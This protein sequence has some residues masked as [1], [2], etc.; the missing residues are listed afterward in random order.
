MCNP[1]IAIAITPETL[2]IITNAHYELPQAIMNPDFKYVF[3]VHCS[4][5]GHETDSIMEASNFERLYE[6]D[7]SK[8]NSW[9]FVTD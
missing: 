7:A 2:P 5:S 1:T 3:V 9:T 4:Q 8:L 6:R